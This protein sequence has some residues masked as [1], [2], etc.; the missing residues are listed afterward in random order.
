MFFHPGWNPICCIHCEYLHWS[1][2]AA[3]ETSSNIFKHQAFFSTDWKQPKTSGILGFCPWDQLFEPKFHHFK[4]GLK[5]PSGR[6]VKVWDYSAPPFSNTVYVRRFTVWVNLVDHL[7]TGWVFG[8]FFSTESWTFSK[9]TKVYRCRDA[10]GHLEII[11]FY[12]D[13][14]LSISGQEVPKR[15]TPTFTSWYQIHMNFRVAGESVKG[16]KHL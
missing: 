13:G 14:N 7:T 11:R 15:G 4:L 3:E 2:L 16:R 12:S 8:W 1:T 6:V 5:S 10:T 9:K